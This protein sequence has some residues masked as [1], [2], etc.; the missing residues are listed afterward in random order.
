MVWMR[1]AGLPNFRK[2]WGRINSNLP[3][4]TYNLKITNTYD[5]SSFEGSKTFIMSTTNIFGGKNDFLA[6]SFIGAA[7]LSFIFTIIFVVAGIKKAR[8]E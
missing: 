1:T 2:I 7:A 4:G 6:Y 3:A 5:V 8:N